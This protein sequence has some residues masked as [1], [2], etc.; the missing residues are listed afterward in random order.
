[1]LS[2]SII[3][4]F[5][6]GIFSLA[7]IHAQNDPTAVSILKKSETIYKSFKNIDAKFEINLGNSGK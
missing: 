7:L 3:N 4:T 5:F 6:I 1:M 2:K